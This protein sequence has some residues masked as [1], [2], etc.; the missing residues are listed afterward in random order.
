MKLLC[1]SQA[2]YAPFGC[3]RCAVSMTCVIK[4]YYKE[5]SE[6]SHCFVFMDPW[7]LFFSI[8]LLSTQT[9]LNFC[10]IPSHYPS[11]SLMM[12]SIQATCFI[13]AR[14]SRPPPRPSC[15]KHQCV[16]QQHIWSSDRTEDMLHYFFRLTSAWWTLQHK[17]H[18]ILLLLKE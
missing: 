6:I 7:L 15:K 3:I 14:L 10:C 16:S 4:Y 17:H 11:L 9:H 12:C 5:S 8:A 2:L 18:K 1:Y 13:P